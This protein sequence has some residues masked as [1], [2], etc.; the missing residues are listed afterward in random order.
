MFKNLGGS[1]ILIAL[2]ADGILAT[3]VFSP[4]MSEKLVCTR[5][6]LPVYLIGGCLLSSLFVCFI[7]EKLLKFVTLVN[8][9]V[10]LLPSLKPNSNLDLS[11][12]LE[13]HEKVGI[14]YQQDQTQLR[15]YCI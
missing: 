1:P 14:L 12:D 13:L 4:R 9:F 5:Q 8:Y 6:P 2:V 15:I 10:S 3:K 7:Y 11:G